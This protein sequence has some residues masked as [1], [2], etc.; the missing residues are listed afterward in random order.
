[1]TRKG[2]GPPNTGVCRVPRK[3][4]TMVLKRPSTRL[5][6]QQMPSL[7]SAVACYRD[8]ELLLYNTRA[9]RR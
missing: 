6:R 9:D 3:W 8:S 7:V 1:M 2:A 4:R 5:L